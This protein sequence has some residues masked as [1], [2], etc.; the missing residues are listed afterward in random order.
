MD[1]YISDLT[2][3]ISFRDNQIE[4]RQREIFCDLST[5]KIVEDSMTVLALTL[6]LCKK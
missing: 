5:H 3:A 2:K 4:A 6:R 1:H